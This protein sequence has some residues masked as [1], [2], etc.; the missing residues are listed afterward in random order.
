MNRLI[1]IH[2]IRPAVISMVIFVL[3]IS[4]LLPTFPVA[5][6]EQVTDCS[7]PA[8]LIS[9]MASGGTVSF[10]CGANPP[11]IVLTSAFI[12]A[13]N[14]TLDGGGSITLSGGNST[15][16]FVV[17][18]NTTLTLTNITVVNGFDANT[19]GGAVINNGSLVI[20]NSKFFDN[21]TTS[22]WSGGAIVSYGPLSITNSEFTRN[23]AAKGGAIY[24]ASGTAW[25]TRSAFFDNSA[26]TG[27][28]IE[29]GGGD[30]F[31]TDGVFDRNSASGSS[32]SSGGALSQVGG[33]AT[34]ANVTLSHNRTDFRGGAI[35]QANGNTRLTNVTLSGNSASFG[36]GIEQEGGTLALTH[37]TLSGNSGADPTVGG[38]LQINAGTL[39]LVNTLVAAS[40][41]PN[42]NFVAGAI[43]S[44]S[45][46]LSTD[47]TCGFGAGHDGAFVP[48]GPLADNGGFTQTHLPLAGS[49][50]IDHA[51]PGCPATDQRGVTRPQGAAC[52][53]GAVEVRPGEPAARIFLPVVFH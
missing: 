26:G 39:N 12:I 29:H 11:P 44:S 47:S 51:G 50:A 42:C 3:T 27:G 45:F 34:L 5:A 4:I 48:L 40:H 52:D 7:S 18:P 25:L 53:V 37:V 8:D 10:N 36:G 38:G 13:Q 6:S 20:S 23:S 46:S 17:S 16:L 24:L 33:N 41:G 14:T 35:A 30:L 28:A 32:A 15:L 9:K 2:S 31:L 43:L 1:L 22:P 19:D 21:Q 49:L